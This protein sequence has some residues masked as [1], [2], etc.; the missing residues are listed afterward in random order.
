MSCLA[1]AISDI[2]Y[3]S[4]L[5]IFKWYLLVH[6]AGEMHVL[7][8]VCSAAF[9]TRTERRPETWPRLDSAAPGHETAWVQ[10]GGCSTRLSS[11]SK[12]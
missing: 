11:K 2:K 8:S 1:R 4:L 9:R 12:K 6:K 5:I 7:G 10:V 3:T